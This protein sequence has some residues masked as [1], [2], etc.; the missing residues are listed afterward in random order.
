MVLTCPA[1]P[2]PPA[3][4]PSC[5][6]PPHLQPTPWHPTTHL[7]A[8][9]TYQHH[10]AVTCQVSS[11]TTYHP[12]ATTSTESPPPAPCDGD[13]TCLC[14]LPHD[15]PPQSSFLVPTHPAPRTPQL[16]TPRH[17]GVPSGGSQVGH[18]HHQHRNDTVAVT[19][20]QTHPTT[21]THPNPQTAIPNARPHT[22]KRTA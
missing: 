14:A 9:P 22:S 13:P 10:L 16:V 15:P 7:P 17:P 21:H 5:L 6:P 3:L 8:P 20:F 19:D 2:P 11:T 18:H 1:P 12:P 4:V